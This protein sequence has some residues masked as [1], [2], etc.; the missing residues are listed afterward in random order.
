MDLK[1]APCEVGEI[2]KCDSLRGNA[3]CIPREM[4]EKVGLLDK[5]LP[6]VSG[7]LD[8]GLRCTKAGFEI[9]MLGDARVLETEQFKEAARRWTDPETS[10]RQVWR[11]FQFPTSA[12]YYPSYFHYKTR[13][14]GVAGFVSFFFP[15]TRCAIITV[16]K[17]VLNR[18]RKQKEEAPSET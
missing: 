13:H 17:P 4:F 5:K 10:I 2:V 15:Y 12:Y 11:S 14:W 1:F 3:V 8:F 9:H 7:D 16:L 6:M 18:V